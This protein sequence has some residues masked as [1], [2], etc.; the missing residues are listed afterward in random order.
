MKIKEVRTGYFNIK[1]KSPFKI[2]LGTITEAQN[3]VVEIETDQGHK[4]IGEAAPMPLVTGDTQEGIA[5][6]IHKYLRPILLEEDPRQI[7]KLSGKLKS[8]LQGN[9]GAHVAVEM[10]LFDLLGEIYRIPLYILWGGNSNFFEGDC[11]VSLDTP[12]VMAEKAKEIVERGYSYIKIKVGEGL[13]KDLTKISQISEKIGSQASLRLDANQG[14][15]VK[16][17]IQIIKKLEKYNIDL[18]EEPISRGNL[19]GM[20]LIRSRANIPIMADETVFNPRE[21]L[22]VIKAGAADLINIKLMKAGGI[23]AAREI[24]GLART[25][26]LE[27]M[28]G[29][30]LESRVAITAAAHLVASSPNITRADLDSPLILERDPVQGGVKIEGEK[31][32]LP[33]KPGLGVK[34]DREE[35]QFLE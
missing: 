24:D 25:A 26:G 3:V 12:A 4:G 27:C 14:W 31:Y 7:K 9:P 23:L 21:A 22:A 33:E 20:V 34:L 28:V 17:A 16:E 13:E 5:L 18:L 10:A 8:S 29:C 1:L 32:I 19:E 2:S 15:D 35:I 11:T 30:M 6:A